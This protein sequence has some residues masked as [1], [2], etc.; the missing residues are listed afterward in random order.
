MQIVGDGKIAMVGVMQC[1]PGAKHDILTWRMISR[2][3]DCYNLESSGNRGEQGADVGDGGEAD[4]SSS[5]ER[6]RF[7]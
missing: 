1:V 7:R 6:L 2:F 4:C 3:L 5:P